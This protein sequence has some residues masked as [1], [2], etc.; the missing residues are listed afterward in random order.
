[1]GQINISRIASSQSIIIPPFGVDGLYNDSGILYQIDNV[2][3]IQP[4]GAV[5]QIAV[6]MSN[7]DIQNLLTTPKLLIPGGG[8]GVVTQVISGYIN[9]N[10]TSAFTPGGSSVVLELY[11]GG[12][13][14]TFF[15]NCIQATQS[16]R[17]RFIEKHDP[18]VQN[19]TTYT[20]NNDITLTI[21]TTFSTGSA[22]A[23]VYLSYTQY[24]ENLL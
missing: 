6:T 7:S 15:N 24:N 12:N 11:E 13:E 23:V 10:L 20:T 21:G 14:E 8:N 1:M 5:K 4:L 16:G 3:S 19:I 18:L 9:L 2:G 22:S 17:F